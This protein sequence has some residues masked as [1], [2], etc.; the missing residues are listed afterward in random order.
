MDDLHCADPDTNKLGGP[1]FVMTSTLLHVGR[2]WRRHCEHVLTEH[3]ISEA[4]AT[5]LLWA[6]R[7]GGGVRQV[8]LAPYVGVQDTSIIRLLDELGTVGLIER[9][10]DPDDLRDSILADVS[11]AD[12]EATLRMFTALDR[13]PAPGGHQDTAKVST[14][15]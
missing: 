10:E 14:S 2:Q 3:D 4:R 15:P 5:A 13:P 12:I 6:A 11:D 9:R 1:R 8:Q 7:L